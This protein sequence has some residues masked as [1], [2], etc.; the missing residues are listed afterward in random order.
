VGSNP[1]RPAVTPPAI[2]PYI[3][4]LQKEG[5][6]PQTIESHSKILRFL[7]KHVPLN[8]SEA[9]RL[10]VAN[11]HVSGGRKENEVD[12]FSSFARYHKI[13]FSEPR[14]SREETLPFIAL[15][16]EM[17]Q[18]INACRSL[19]HATCLR[20]LKETAMRIG[21]AAR[22]QF[23]DFDFEKRTVRVMPEKG[24]RPRELRLSER[25]VAMIQQLFARK[26]SL[27]T[28]ES[29][30]HYLENTRKILAETN[31]NPRFLQIHLHSFRHFRATMLYAQ[32]RDLL[33]V[34]KILGHRSITN[35]IRYTQLVDFKDGESFI[36]KVAKSAEEAVK[37]IENGF[38]FVSSFPDGIQLYKKRK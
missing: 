28:A 13:A 14:Y 2:F 31:N 3:Q 7:S 15:E 4:Y 23:K 35:T 26:Q 29:A 38:E 33:Y 1:T 34:M 20:L 11:Q 17:E 36:C 25:L 21:E 8:D 19:R 18:I 5:F 10:F 16:V 27:P 22:L 6:K 9:I 37:L 12:V 32:T 24:S 30:R